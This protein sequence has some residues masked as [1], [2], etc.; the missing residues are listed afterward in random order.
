MITLRWLTLRL[1]WSLLVLPP[2]AFLVFWALRRVFMSGTHLHDELI[3]ICLLVLIF[4]TVSILLT[5]IGIRRFKFIHTYGKIFS[6]TDDEES[7]YNIYHLTLNLFDNGLLANKQKDK[8]QKS[9]LRNYFSIYARAPENLQNRNYLLQAL[10]E[11]I[12]SEEVYHILKAYVLNQHIITVEISEITEELL[13][14][15]PNDLTL[16]NYFVERFLKERRTHFR[17]EYFYQLHLKH[18]GTFV[19][20][21]L[22]LNLDRIIEKNR[23]DE[24]AAWAYV[25]AFQSNIEEFTRVKKNLYLLHD[26][27]STQQRQDSLAQAVAKCVAAFKPEEIKFWQIERAKTQQTSFRFRIEQW[28]YFIQQVYWEAISYVRENYIRVISIASI[29]ALIFILYLATPAELLRTEH[30]QEHQFIPIDTHHYFSLQVGA[31]KNKKGADRLL[32]VMRKKG[33]DVYSLDPE[34]RR[35]WYRIKAGKYKTVEEA[36]LA[37]DSLKNVGVIRDFF[38]SNYEGKIQ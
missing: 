33:L 14:H 5:R 19:Q 32:Q 22:Y 24:F 1:F 31:V 23:N 30:K 20:S 12:R 13:D 9:L 17:A 37:A 38:I 3:F 35:G 15:Q 29:F 11:G 18:E 34:K 2:L 28:F 4:P 7:A 6:Q 10:R 36:R 16:I 21:I 8:L 26:S 25:R 27:Y